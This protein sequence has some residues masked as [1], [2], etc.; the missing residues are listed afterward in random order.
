MMQVRRVEHADWDEWLQMRS[1]LWPN[2]SPDEHRAEMEEYSMP[3]AKVA[4]FVAM[5]DD[6]TLGG[7]LEA[8]LRPYA[9]GCD[10]KP[11]GYIEGWYV[12]ADLRRTGIGGQLVRAA[13]QWAAEQGC[14]EMAS[15]CLID[16]EVSYHAHLALGYKEAERLIHFRKD[17]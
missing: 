7:F 9:D 11:V 2:T 14:Q 16:N 3:N 6:G 4:T 5:R 12:D 15:D 10:T 8:G 13:E 17:L 1:A